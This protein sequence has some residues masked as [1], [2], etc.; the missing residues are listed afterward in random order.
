MK[1][2]AKRILPIEL[3][4]QLRP[5]YL[6]GRRW[7]GALD[8]ACDKRTLTLPEFIQLLGELGI[9]PGATVM[10]HSSMDEVARRVPKLDALTLVQVLQ[11]ILGQEGTLLMPTFPFLGSQLR[12]AET[13]DSFDPVRTPS[14]VG[15]ATEVF[16]RMPGVVRS[17]H[18]THPIAG[19]G[20]DAADLLAT[21]HLGPTFGPH[22]PLYKLRERAGL[23]VGLGTG[24]SSFTI[25][26]VA[27]ELHSATRE[28]RFEPEP[29]M[30]TIVDGPTRIP[31][32]FRVLKAGI[33]YDFDGL[34]RAFSRGGTL[35][36]VCRSGLQCAAARADLL[37]ERALELIDQKAFFASRW[38]VEAWRR[39]T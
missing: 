1:R 6:R 20:R 29:R 35:K 31:Y 27:E 37:I 2:H 19:W 25:L 4:A 39:A 13:H 21:H 18:P 26:H 10:L 12:Y 3:R 33:E 17:L 32:A 22:S 14:R 11:D 9:T 23:V 5:A 24:L 30:M 8:R 36:S 7:L 16:R 15:L 38:S 28:H 34:V